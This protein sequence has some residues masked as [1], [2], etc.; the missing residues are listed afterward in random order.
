MNEFEISTCLVG[1][2][3]GGESPL[4]EGFEDRESEAKM[5][6][7]IEVDVDKR[8]LVE[9][10]EMVEEPGIASFD[11]VAVTGDVS[12]SRTVR[13]AAHIGDSCDSEA[14]SVALV[15]GEPTKAELQTLTQSF[16]IVVVVETG[17]WI[18]ELLTDLFA[19]LS[20]SMMLHTDYTRINEN[21]KQ[22]SVASVC[23]ATGDRD[24]ITDVV[25]SCNGSGDVLMG[26]A[27]VGSEFTVGDA[28]ELEA[29]LGDER[30]V[31]GQATL[32]DETGIRLTLLRRASVV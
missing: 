22:G 31:G 4:V 13:T 16:E 9:T 18:R 6:P 29:L 5:V 28:E 8:Y 23:R 32:S 12:E 24:D 7:D 26:Y 25:E 30:V 14:V 15:A 17:R 21:L 27:E 10:G 1:I 2:G 11:I 20:Q 19:L 3:E